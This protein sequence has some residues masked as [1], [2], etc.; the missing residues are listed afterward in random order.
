MTSSYRDTVPVTQ[1]SSLFRDTNKL[2]EESVATYPWVKGSRKQFRIKFS[3]APGIVH[4][5]G[6]ARREAL[7]GL[8]TGIGQ[9]LFN[10]DV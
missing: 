10:R 5:T 4:L 2:L 6:F 9:F 1:L 8:Y 3:D 7:G